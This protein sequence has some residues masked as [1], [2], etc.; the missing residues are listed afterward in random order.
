VLPVRLNVLNKNIN[1]QDVDTNNCA[2]IEPPPVAGVKCENGGVSGKDAYEAYGFDR[3]P[4]DWSW[5]GIDRQQCDYIAGND[6]KEVIGKNGSFCDAVQFS[7]ELNKKA[8]EIRDFVEA[9]KGVIDGTAPFADAANET[10]ATRDSAG[11]Y[12]FVKMQ[13]QVNDNSVPGYLGN[14][15]KYYGTVFFLKADN[16]ILESGNKKSLQDKMQGARSLTT[17]GVTNGNMYAIA[18]QTLGALNSITGIADQ[19]RVAGIIRKDYAGSQAYKDIAQLAGIDRPVVSPGAVFDHDVVTLMEYKGLNQL[20]VDAL[21][22]NGGGNKCYKDSA[23]LVEIDYTTE[24]GRKLAVVCAINGTD[25]SAAGL[26]ELNN[27]IESFAVG[28]INAKD[29]EMPDGKDYIIKNAADSKQIELAGKKSFADF[30]YQNIDFNAFLVKDGYTK[31]L[32]EDIA[33]Q[34]NDDAINEPK[35]VATLAATGFGTGDWKFNSKESYALA[36]A[37]LY[38]I[39]LNLDFSVPGTFNWNVAF[40]RLKELKGIKAEYEKNYM[41]SLPFDGSAGINSPNGREGYGVLVDGVGK[42]DLAYDEETKRMTSFSKPSNF[43][44]ANAFGFYT[45]QA[46]DALLITNSGT[47]FSAEEGRIVSNPSKPARVDVTLAAKQGS[48]N[49]GLLYN[50]LEGGYPSAMDPNKWFVWQS[51]GKT[52]ADQTLSRQLAQTLCPEEESGSY[53]GFLQNITGETVFKGLIILP[54]SREYELQ[55]ICNQGSMPN[56]S[57]L[58]SISA[59]AGWRKGQPSNQLMLN[60]NKDIKNSTL[61]HFVESIKDGRMCFTPGESGIALSWNKEFLLQSVEAGK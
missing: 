4:F 43:N 5:D 13:V 39:V 25:V 36:K 20:L 31:D 47:V 49:E 19:R 58:G 12:R 42:I 7:I 44:R 6:G 32:R 48:G 57:A 23:K 33:K 1:V 3:L 29:G 15:D 61:E 34:L 16:A 35:A 11:L 22:G 8:E 51:A 17:A 21:K 45:L 9:N 56:A 54:F 40:N 46:S 2:A 41:F 24:D 28:A 38:G 60:T 30:Y 10:E 27:A 37:G 50:L 14:K 52:F 26:N 59:T 18:E 53:H 55:L